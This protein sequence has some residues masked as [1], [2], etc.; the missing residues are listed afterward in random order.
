MT[1]NQDHQNDNMAVEDALDSD[2]TDNSSCSGNTDIDKT[3]ERLPYISVHA[4]PSRRSTE[5]NNFIGEHP[6][7]LQDEETPDRMSAHIPKRRKTTNDIC[8]LIIT[9]SSGSNIEYRSCRSTL[10]AS[11]CSA[12][13]PQSRSVAPPLGMSGGIKLPTLQI[14]S[15]NRKEKLPSEGCTDAKKY[16]MTDT[17]EGCSS[18]VLNIEPAK[19]LGAQES[20]ETHPSGNLSVTEPESPSCSPFILER[21]GDKVDVSTGVNDAS[22]EKMENNIKTLRS[23]PNAQNRGTVSNILSPQQRNSLPS[24]LG[25]LSE[26]LR[27]HIHQTQS[28]RSAIETSRRKTAEN[29]EHCKD[30]AQ[31]QLNAAPQLQSNIKSTILSSGTSEGQA[32]SKGSPN[33]N[34]KAQPADNY[35]REPLE[36]LKSSGSKDTDGKPKKCTPRSS[37]NQAVIW[38]DCSEVGDGCKRP[39]V[40]RTSDKHI[41]HKYVH[42]FS[43]KGEKFISKKELQRHM[44][45]FMD[46]SSSKSKDRRT[47]SPAE[48]GEGIQTRRRMPPARTALM[49]SHQAKTLIHQNNGTRAGEAVIGCTDVNVADK[50]TASNNSE[51]EKTPETEPRMNVRVNLQSLPAGEHY[52]SEQPAS[53]QGAPSTSRQFGDS[54]QLNAVPQRLPADQISNWENCPKIGVNWKQKIKIRKLGDSKGHRDKYYLSPEGKTFRSKKEVERHL[55]KSMDSSLFL[56]DRTQSPTEKVDGQDLGGKTPTAQKCSAK[57]KN[58]TYNSNE[59]IMLDDDEYNICSSQGMPEDTSN[60]RGKTWIIKCPKETY[61]IYTGE[62]NITFENGNDFGDVYKIKDK[63]SDTCEMVENFELESQMSESSGTEAENMSRKTSDTHTLRETEGEH[64]NVEIEQTE[65]SLQP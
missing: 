63:P 1:A 16:M 20:S 49:D 26:H 23:A 11:S 58:L 48:K 45:K 10:V 9:Q 7:R 46:P 13:F 2:V 55:G 24:K 60:S 59:I 15:T 38:K 5:K 12:K 39:I 47:Q 25:T 22:L 40:A 36:N 3:P 43:P 31:N 8:K 57:Q 35:L 29:A 50:S 53:P 62:H 41:V 51:I 28:V 21:D 54:T 61:Y 27:S 65:T 34:T 4:N 30:D 32:T 37:A 18:H 56:L 33:P 44:D 64:G 17:S 42:Y 19:D 14:H 52:T 6:D